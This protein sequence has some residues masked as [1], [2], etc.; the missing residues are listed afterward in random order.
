MR[1][2]AIHR[3]PPFRCKGFYKSII[4]NYQI[5]VN[6]KNLKC[7]KF[8]I[9]LEKHK[10]LLLFAVPDRCVKGHHCSRMQAA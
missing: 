6:G 9:F 5:F 10:Y 3:P 1:T 8:I 2:A 7:E 4:Y